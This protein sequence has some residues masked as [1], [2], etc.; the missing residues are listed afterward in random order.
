MQSKGAQFNAT[1]S[2]RIEIPKEL[3]ISTFKSTTYPL[4]RLSV[5]RRSNFQHSIIVTCLKFPE[6][7]CGILILFKHAKL[8][9]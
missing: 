1:V 3:V 6:Y 7:S 8:S 5:V 9:Y 2:E 4:V